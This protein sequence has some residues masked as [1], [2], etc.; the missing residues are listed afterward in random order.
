MTGLSEFQVPVPVSGES[1]IPGILR[2]FARRSNDGKRWAGG[3]DEV[4][5]CW[6]K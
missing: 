4:I 2:K 6:R 1:P 3:T 5:D